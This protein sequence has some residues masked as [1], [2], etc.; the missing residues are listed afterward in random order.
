MAF[1]KYSLIRLAIFA[2]LFV[3][4]LYL[5]LG[6]VLSVVCAAAMAF[7][8]SYIFFQKQRNAAAASLQR[9]VTGKATPL[10]SL[11]EIND[12][13]AEDAMVDANPDVQV[14]NDIKKTNA[15]K[16]TEG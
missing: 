14:R 11:T 4:F 16:S 15:R 3:L 1:L 8:V 5:Q 7:S 6:A 2:P 13:E 9:R 12:A 10:R